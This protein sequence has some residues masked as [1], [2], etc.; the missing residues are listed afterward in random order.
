M[1]IS[2]KKMKKIRCIKILIFYNSFFVN[3]HS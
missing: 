2:E 3:I 1:I